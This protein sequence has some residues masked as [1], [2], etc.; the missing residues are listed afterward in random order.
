[1]L[2][3]LSP[4]WRKLNVWT[5]ACVSRLHFRRKF[6]FPYKREKQFR[7]SRSCTQSRIQ[8]SLDSGGE[9]NCRISFLSSSSDE[10]ARSEFKTKGRL[11]CRVFWITSVPFFAEFIDLPNP[12][13]DPLVE[14]QILISLMYS[15]RYPR[16]WEIFLFAGEMNLAHNF[17]AFR[18]FDP[19]KFHIQYIFYYIQ[20]SFTF[21]K[22]MH[23]LLKQ[24]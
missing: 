16:L 3:A 13:W 15:I 20:Y 5:I 4:Q 2:A 14:E 8:N 23:L 6:I 7:G 12:Q 1:M 19:R 11:S 17:T 22:Y 24:I 18:D 9:E 21:Q 10:L